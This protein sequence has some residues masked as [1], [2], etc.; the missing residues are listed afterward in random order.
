MS[1]RD[2]GEIGRDVHRKVKVRMLALIMTMVVLSSLDRT[3][4]SF[5]A[6]QMNAALGLDKQSFGFGASIFFVGYLAFQIP[7]M[8]LLKKIG[9]R[10]WIFLTVTVWGVLAA[11]MAFIQ[12][13]TQFYALR[14]LI[15]VAESGF[16]PGTMYYIS[17]WLPSAYRGR[18]ITATML[19]IPVSVV[20]GAPI[21]GALLGVHAAA[22]PGWRWMFLLEGLPTVL[23]GLFALVWFVDRPREAKWLT[24]EE[25]DWIER[26]IATDDA[27]AEARS[28]GQVGWAPI[29][30]NP[31]IWCCAGVWFAFVTGGNGIIFWLPQAIKAIAG[32]GD[33]ETSLLS[34]LPWVAVAIGMVVNA[35]RSDK[36]QERFY[37]VGLAALLGAVGLTAA[38]LSGGGLPALAWLILGGF[39]L[40]ACQAVYWTIPL[41]LLSGGQAANGVAVINL[42]GNVGSLLIPTAIGFVIQRTGSFNAPV[43]GMAALLIAAALLLIPIARAD[44]RQ[45]A[46]A[47]AAA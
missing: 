30:A 39:G 43:Y 12:N 29:L 46:A 42:A 28:G 31:L 17:R 38:A 22:F 2:P 6:L 13:A 40:G 41:R 36:T 25:K 14:L 24:A 47:L 45:S 1:G 20:I 35:W 37:H 5:A 7:S 27:E 11:A 15:G 23:L 10:R 16:A 44:R 3:N 32:R 33:F 9:A 34:A 4:I 26:G 19:A 21:S 18:S 8:M